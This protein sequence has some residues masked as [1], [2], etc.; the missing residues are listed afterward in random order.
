MG[1]GKEQMGKKKNI[2]SD[3]KNKGQGKKEGQIITQRR[4]S[5]EWIRA[6]K[7]KEEEWKEG[8]EQREW[9]CRKADLSKRKVRREGKQQSV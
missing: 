4:V 2:V 1:T 7:N 9:S 5:E 3:G 6:I 8:K